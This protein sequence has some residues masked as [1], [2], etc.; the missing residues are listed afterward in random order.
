VDARIDSWVDA[1][2]MSSLEYLSVVHEKDETKLE[3]YLID[4]G[5]GTIRAEKKG[6]VRTISYDGEP[7]LDPLAFTYA[8]R[9]KASEPGQSFE[10][11]MHTDEGPLE[12]VSQVTRLKR[13]RTMD[14]R[15]ELLRVQPNPA[16]GEMFSRKG[17]FVMWVDPAPG[18][19]LYR[20]DFK[21]GFGRLIAALDGA[22]DSIFDD[23]EP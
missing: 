10:L 4:P 3:R 17:E 8:V 20:L 12:T 13:K 14:G 23:E 21:L 9:A 7:A 16:D 11:R 18:R 2:T 15:R 6:K 1:A 5:E 19:T 22:D